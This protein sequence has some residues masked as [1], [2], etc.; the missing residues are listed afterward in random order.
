M[1]RSIIPVFCMSA[2]FQACSV[3]GRHTSDAALERTFRQHEAEFEA[4][5][6]DV[7]ADQEL[8]TLQPEVLIY[9]GHYWKVNE[10]GHSGLAQE[11][12]D[13]YQQ[14][15]RDLGLCSVIQ[16]E[17]RVEFRVDPGSLS[18]GDSYKGYE[19]NPHPPP[20]LKKSL[21]G[22]RVSADDRDR[23]GG[24]LAYKPLNGNWYLYLFVN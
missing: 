8:T 17:G 13:R 20:R 9:A 5:L 6:A 24:W 14:R 18:N 23:Y 4:F 21:D 22:Y 16:S 19:Y 3:G 1:N 11:R 12:W 2:L 7:Q 15:L 10:I